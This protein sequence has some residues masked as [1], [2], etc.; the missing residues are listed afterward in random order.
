MGQPFYL[1]EIALLSCFGGRLFALGCRGFVRLLIILLAAHAAAFAGVAK[2][3]RSQQGDKN[4]EVFHGA[5]S[6]ALFGSS[7]KSHC[8]TLYAL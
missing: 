5:F 1:F 7:R 2:R 3:G 8:F 6:L 4:E